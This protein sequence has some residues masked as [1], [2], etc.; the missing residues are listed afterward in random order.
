MSG[1]PDGERY[2]CAATASLPLR[3]LVLVLDIVPDDDV[4]PMEIVTRLRCGLEA[5]GSGPHFDLVRE[6]KDASRGEV[7]VHWEHDE[8]PD[9]VVVLPD[10]PAVNSRPGAEVDACTLFASHPGGHCFEF[11]DP[12]YDAVRVSPEYERFTAEWDERLSA[13]PG[14]NEGE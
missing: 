9:S 8:E 13:P 3:T 7:W 4:H 6:L 12:E 10:C 1:R 11:S 2:I 14:R 5:H